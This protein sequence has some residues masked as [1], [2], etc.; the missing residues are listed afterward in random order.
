MIKSICVAGFLIAVSGC[1]SRPEPTIVVKD[2]K[3]KDVYIDKL[4]SIVSEAGAG[5]TAVLEVTPRPSIEYSTLEAE[6]A[7]LGGIKPPTV[8][9]LAEKRLIIKNNDTKAV[10]KDKV[11]AD[12]VEEETS[13]L[14]GRVV[15]LDSELAEAKAEKELALQAE[16]RAVKDKILYMMTCV[17]V[18]MFA[19]GVLIIAFTPKKVS[20]GIIISFGILATS[21]AWV[22]DSKWFGW[23][24][25]VGFGLVVG[26][27][28]LLVSKKTFDYLRAKRTGQEEKS[29]QPSN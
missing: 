4:E 24:A 8:A 11:K 16:A 19:V 6:N 12:K 2:N 5:I 21:A 20:G 27:I 1:A 25:G 18:A 29:E 17:G 10:A 23:I 3:E 13:V 7:R 9:K 28:I 26:H 22:F 14:Y 15:A